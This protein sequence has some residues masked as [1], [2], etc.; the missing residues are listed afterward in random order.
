MT[1]PGVATTIEGIYGL[2]TSA[3]IT[4]MTIG[5]RSYALGILSREAMADLSAWGTRI[6]DAQKPGGTPLSAADRDPSR[7]L[8]ALLRAGDP[9]I[10]FKFVLPYLKP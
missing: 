3:P 2:A 8:K 7:I 6:V 10:N 9:T 4:E 1:V 5:R